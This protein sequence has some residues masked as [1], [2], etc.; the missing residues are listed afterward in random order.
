MEES[1]IERKLLWYR[2]SEPNP[3]L[4][5]WYLAIINEPSQIRIIKQKLYDQL[6][7]IV[8]EKEI[9]EGKIEIS[10]NLHYELFCLITS[11]SKIDY[12]KVYQGKVKQDRRLQPRRTQEGWNDFIEKL[13]NGEI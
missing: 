8:E 1:K 13:H 10:N 5:H 11:T 7:P 9:D 4:H 12:S 3:E 2:Y 6:Q